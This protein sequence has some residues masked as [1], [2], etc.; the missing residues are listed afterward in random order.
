MSPGIAR[1]RLIPDEVTVRKVI[2]KV[3]VDCAPS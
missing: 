1:L 3:S 2:R